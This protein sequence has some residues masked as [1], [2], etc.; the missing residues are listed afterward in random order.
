MTGLLLSC[1]VLLVLFA[2]RCVRSIPQIKIL[3]KL[4]AEETAA[5]GI[6]SEEILSLLL[7][8]LSDARKL[9]LSGVRGAASAYA[10]TLGKAR[11]L[12]ASMRL[13]QL[14]A[15]A[16]IAGK[17][18]SKR[19]NIRMPRIPHLGIRLKHLHLFE[20]PPL[21]YLDIRLPFF[22]FLNHDP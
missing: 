9:S 15:L 11:L 20:I 19:W 16:T 7:F 13:I 12:S 1:L 18:S 21:P 22:T 5:I 14:F 6:V 8:L 3:P 10:V 4:R 2:L 17:Y